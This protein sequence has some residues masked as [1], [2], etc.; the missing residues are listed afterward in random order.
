[1]LINGSVLGDFS[2]EFLS[3]F[4]MNI[5]YSCIF[6]QFFHVGLQND[7]HTVVLYKI[8]SHNQN[9]DISHLINVCR[10][11]SIYCELQLQPM[12]RKSNFEDYFCVNFHVF[13]V[14]IGFRMFYR[15]LD[16]C[17]ENQ[18]FQKYFYVYDPVS[19][20]WGSKFGF[21]LF[22]IKK[23]F[24]FHKKS[25][26]WFQSQTLSQSNFYHTWTLRNHFF[27]CDACCW[28]IPIGKKTKLITRKFWA[29][30]VN[31]LIEGFVFTVIVGTGNRAKPMYFYAMFNQAVCSK[32]N[33][34]LTS[35]E[36]FDKVQKIVL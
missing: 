30:L 27:S 33:R 26:H 21:F 2:G 1:M 4:G 19:V 3:V 23:M 34:K 22:Q 11:E 35:F 14:Q 29:F 9:I 18:G 31:S 15:T 12:G 32:R 8:S 17:I 36:N 25:H 20:S 10:N 7:S 16:A 24:S 6:L 5:A 13:Q 28:K